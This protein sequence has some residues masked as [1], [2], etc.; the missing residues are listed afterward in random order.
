MKK[1]F[2]RELEASK[3]DCSERARKYKDRNLEEIIEIV[4]IRLFRDD[5]GHREMDRDFLG[6]NPIE[7]KNL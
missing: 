3:I 7:E 5:I 2:I 4:P 6:L 1:T